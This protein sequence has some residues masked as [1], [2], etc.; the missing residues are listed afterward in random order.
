MTG[1]DDNNEDAAF[2]GDYL[3]VSLAAA[4][5]LVAAVN[6]YFVLDSSGSLANKAPGLV[7]G[8]IFY[9]LLARAAWRRTA[10]SRRQRRAGLSPGN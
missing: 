10:W 5:L 8:T 6:L 2:L 3:W 4:V 7:F 1:N 9:G